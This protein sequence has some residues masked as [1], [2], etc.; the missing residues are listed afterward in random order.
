MRYLQTIGVATT[1]CATLPWEEYGC[2][3]ISRNRARETVVNPLQAAPVEVITSPQNTQ[4]TVIGF[5][6]AVRRR[7]NLVHRPVRN[8]MQVQDV[9]RI[10]AG[11]K[12]SD[13]Y[14]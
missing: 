11:R 12:S 2:I 5:D 6:I 7:L 13:R 3:G 14:G 9:S 4:R 10:S 1:V 8:R